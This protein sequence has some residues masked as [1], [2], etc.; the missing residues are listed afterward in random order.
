MKIIKEDGFKY[1]TVISDKTKPKNY[2]KANWIFVLYR[3]GWRLIFETKKPKKCKLIF[4][5]D[6]KLSAYKNL[7]QLEKE[8]WKSFNNSWSFDRIREV[9]DSISNEAHRLQAPSYVDDLKKNQACA[10]DGVRLGYRSGGNANKE[11]A[12]VIHWGRVV[13]EAKNVV[14]IET[15]IGSRV[16]LQEFDESIGI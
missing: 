7:A 4:K 11:T 2:N 13:N 9:R 8:W 3:F 10:S 6:T 1:K 16:F 12:I 5:R 14:F 15:P